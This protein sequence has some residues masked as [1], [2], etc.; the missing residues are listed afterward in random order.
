MFH[1]LDPRSR[2]TR[3]SFFAAIAVTAVACHPVPVA[4]PS[5]GGGAGG[6]SGS[7]FE[8]PSVGAAEDVTAELGSWTLQGMVFTPEALPP[9][10]MRL[11]RVSP[12]VPLAKARA[13]WAKLARDGK[14]PKGPK[15]TA[16]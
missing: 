12:P 4:G 8:E 6:G 5:G 9:T 14:P 3:L 13:Q 16:A 7:G 11:V 2:I 10:P 1:R 15:A